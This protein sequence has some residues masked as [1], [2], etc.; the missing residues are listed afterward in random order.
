MSIE[1]GED[2]GKTAKI[3]VSVRVPFVNNVSSD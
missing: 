3:A 1:I 2:R